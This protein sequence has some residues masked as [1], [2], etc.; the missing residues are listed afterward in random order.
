MNRCYCF[1]AA[2][3]RTMNLMDA[4]MPSRTQCGRFCGHFA[5]H[6]IVGP[7]Q[8]KKKLHTKSHDALTAFLEYIDICQQH[9][10]VYLN[11]DKIFVDW[12]LWSADASELY[13][14]KMW[15]LV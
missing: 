12:A 8:S 3:K 7:L 13:A 2:M 9:G 4:Q 10:A 6:Q 1:S 5:N 14:A 11:L 15:K